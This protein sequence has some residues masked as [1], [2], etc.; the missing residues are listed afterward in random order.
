M[1]LCLP[2]LSIGFCFCN[3]ENIKGK[4]SLKLLSGKYLERLIFN[5]RNKK[6]S[7]YYLPT[8]VAIKFPDTGMLMKLA[9]GSKENSK[10]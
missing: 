3:E 6:K 9:K 4:Q 7:E 10:T 1:V 2:D 8:V 5:R